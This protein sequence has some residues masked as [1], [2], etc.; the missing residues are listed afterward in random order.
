MLDR[1]GK[2]EHEL[3]I[4]H[5]LH[6]THTTTLAEYLEQFNTLVDNLVAY[7]CPMDPMYFVQKFV[8]RIH[9]DIRAPVFVQLL[10]PWML[11]ALL[12]EEVA[13]SE[14]KDTHHTEWPWTSKP[15]SKG[16]LTLPL[17]PTTK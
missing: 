5:L 4:R 14:K 9:A 1:F 2:D 8:D 11:L 6:I 10:H 7:G 13:G 3:F 12:Q 16:P 15:S 17:P